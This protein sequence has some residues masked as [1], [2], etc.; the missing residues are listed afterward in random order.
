MYAEILQEANDIIVSSSLVCE[1]YIEEME[2]T[3]LYEEGVSNIT[4]AIRKS[5]AALITKLKNLF[6]S[7]AEKAQEANAKKKKEAALAKLRELPPNAKVPM[8]DFKAMTQVAQKSEKYTVKVIIQL[9]KDLRRAFAHSNDGRSVLIASMDELQ[10]RYEDFEREM[11]KA[12]NHKVKVGA[13]EAIRILETDPEIFVKKFSNSVF[14]ALD[15]LENTYEQIAP[16]WLSDTTK[17][18]A[19]SDKGLAAKR[20]MSDR[21]SGKRNPEIKRSVAQSVKRHI[22]RTSTAFFNCCVRHHKIV[23]PLLLLDTVYSSIIAINKV[24]LGAATKSAP[25]MAAGGVDAGIAYLKHKSRKEI[26]RTARNRFNEDVESYQVAMDKEYIL[27]EAEHSAEVAKVLSTGTNICESYLGMII[28]STEDEVYEESI[29]DAISNAA[30]T[31]KKMVAS[32]IEKIKTF[33]KKVK[34]KIS[35]KF[36]MKERKELKNALENIPTNA[37]IEVIDYKSMEKYAKACVSFSNN[38][39]H[40]YH[41]ETNKLMEKIVKGKALPSDMR[42]LTEKYRKLAEE[43][44]SYYA[45]NIKAARERKIKIPISEAKKLL[46]S[47][48]EGMANAYLLSVSA[49]IESVSFNLKTPLGPFVEETSKEKTP[50]VIKEEVGVVKQALST[51]DSFAIQ[52]AKVVAPVLDVLG[53]ALLANAFI[54]APHG[55]VRL[56]V[57]KLSKTPAANLRRAQSLG[58]TKKRKMKDAVAMAGSVAGGAAAIDY[59]TRIRKKAAATNESTEMEEYNTMENIYMEGANVDLQRTCHTAK[60][61]FN[62]EM[63]DMKRNIRDMDFKGAAENAKAAEEAIKTVKNALKKYPAGDLTTNLLGS[64]I[65]FGKITV[66]SLAWSLVPLFGNVKAV[67][68]GFRLSDAA[69]TTKWKSIKN[70]QEGKQDHTMYNTLYVDCVK[71]LESMERKLAK[72]SQKLRTMKALDAITKE[73]VMDHMVA[74]E[75]EK[76]LLAQFESVDPE[77]LDLM[78]CEGFLDTEDYIELYKEATEEEYVDDIFDES[79]NEFDFDFESDEEYDES[80]DDYEDD[81]YYEGYEDD[82]D[83]D[84]DDFDL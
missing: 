52:H 11:E 19:R 77:M 7:S 51:I 63:R 44:F 38:L 28:E 14:D 35:S 84:F 22:E 57:F 75:D 46:D 30:K 64:V 58:L 68:D 71:W 25:M 70:R 55:R 61:V 5:V 32:M 40:S 83:Y 16:D 37:K 26:A 3:G 13:S 34:D 9:E 50:P 21:E 73:S 41:V 69:I 8:C 47:S 12:K 53:G 29:K 24:S 20:V 39:I 6:R 82:E 65:G 67:M 60:K 17:A 62:K 56:T 72:V 74:E 43:K 42:R 79:A 80:Y 49:S 76:Y 27:L 2:E 45:K 15:K 54:D 78:Y 66:K 31:V 36:G 48:L 1:S 18:N 10:K 23:R 33:F 81:D 4:T 59:A